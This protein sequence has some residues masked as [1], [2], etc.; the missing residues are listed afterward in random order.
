M[1]YVELNKIIRECGIAEH[2]TALTEYAR[3]VAIMV[4]GREEL[5]ESKLR[6]IMEELAL[7]GPVHEFM[8]LAR[9]V[10]DKLVQR[11]RI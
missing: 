3:R 9:R 7:E 4:D 11:E 8:T 5:L 2:N 1:N 6:P 10:R